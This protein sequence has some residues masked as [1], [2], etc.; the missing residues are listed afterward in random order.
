VCGV[1]GVAVGLV[2]ER[3]DLAGSCEPL[4]KE[5]SFEGQKGS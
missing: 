3:F 2:A 4:L 1:E 5:F